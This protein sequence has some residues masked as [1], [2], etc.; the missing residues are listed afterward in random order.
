MLNVTY[1]F[2]YTSPV[3]RY[4]SASN[5]VCATL[6]YPD[7]KSFG[8]CITIA[9]LGWAVVVPGRIISYLAAVGPAT[10]NIHAWHG[11]DAQPSHTAPND[12]SWFVCEWNVTA[13][14]LLLGGPV[15]QSFFFLPRKPPGR[16]TS[17][18]GQKV[19]PLSTT[20]IYCQ[21][22]LLLYPVFCSLALTI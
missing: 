7:D 10:Y 3:E 2:P 9:W 6:W 20:A 12:I 21:I 22:K 13:T 11:L 17:R 4:S 18:V 8:S 16:R 1:P 14:V 19:T 5:S 15:S